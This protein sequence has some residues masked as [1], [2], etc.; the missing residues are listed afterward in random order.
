M[1]ML[2]I[3]CSSHIVCLLSSQ[4]YNADFDG[5]EM[6]MHFPQNELARAEA[7]LIGSA[8][9][10]YLSPTSG[11]PLRGLIQDHVVTGVWLSSKATFFTREKYCQILY[12]ALRPDADGVAL[13]ILTIPPAI[14]KPQSLW[15]GKQVVSFVRHLRDTGFCYHY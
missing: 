8:G 5:D 13:P 11:A 7:M 3:Q 14:Q 15:T 2:S 10:Q 4:S 1:I 6:N 9:E 12:G